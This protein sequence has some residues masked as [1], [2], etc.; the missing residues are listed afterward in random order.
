MTMK[1]ICLYFNNKHKPIAQ[2]E[3]E[4]GIMMKHQIA[5]LILQYSDLVTDLTKIRVV[6]ED[7]AE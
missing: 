4:G 5:N 3:T 7:T 6:I 1:R 2:V